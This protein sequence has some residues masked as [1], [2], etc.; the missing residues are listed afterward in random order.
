MSVQSADFS[1]A[2]SASDL[3]AWKGEGDTDCVANPLLVHILDL[4]AI[5]ADPS[6]IYRKYFDEIAV[7]A[8]DVYLYREE[9]NGENVF[10]INL[11]RD[12]YDQLDVISFG[13]RTKKNAGAVRIAL[14]AFF[15]SAKYQVHYEEGSILN[16]VSSLLDVK[17]YPRTIE[18][19]GYHQN[20]VNMRDG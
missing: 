13:I 5:R 18:Q 19:N 7:G 17:T 6:R 12:L 3:V 14:R 20:L 1:V 2:V 4:L 10:A 16:S 15:D 8:G 11:F 9:V